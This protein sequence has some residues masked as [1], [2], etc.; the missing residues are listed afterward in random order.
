MT[1]EQAQRLADKMT[2]I[3]YPDFDVRP[4]QDEVLMLHVQDRLICGALH[5]LDERSD[6]SLKS[7]IDETVPV[8]VQEQPEPAEHVAQA[9]EEVE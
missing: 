8:P 2:R 5:A 1:P 6:E 3:G 7:L 9:V 4:G